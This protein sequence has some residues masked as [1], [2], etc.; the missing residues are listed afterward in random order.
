[1]QPIPRHPISPRSNLILS[2]TYVL[3]FPVVSFPLSFLPINFT[4]SSSPHL[5]Y[6]PCPSHSTRLDLRIML[7]EEYKSRNS[8]LRS[9]LH[10]PATPFLFGPNILLSTLFSYTLS[11][12]FSLKVRD[13]VSHLYR[14]TGK[15]K[16]LYILMFTFDSRRDD[17][18]F[19]PEC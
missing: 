7:S 11:L 2:I 10:P 1:M 9:F 18:R 19:W 4:R 13:H 12:C 6:M 3:V 17:R 14:S 5:C 15:I 8:S 16:V